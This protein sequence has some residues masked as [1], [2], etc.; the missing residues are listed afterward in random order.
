M[1]AKTPKEA[2]I[3]RVIRPREIAALTGLSLATIWRR[4]KAGDFPR[5]R[6]ISPGAVG[7]LASEI[8]EWLSGREPTAPDTRPVGKARGDSPG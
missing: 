3:D 4:E 2:E 8:R 5:R 6:Q 1:N 7:W